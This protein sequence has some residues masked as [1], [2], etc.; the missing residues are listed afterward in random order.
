MAR[1]LRRERP[2][3]VGGNGRRGGKLLRALCPTRG[4]PVRVRP[5]DAVSG[6]LSLP[7]AERRSAHR[8]EIQLPVIVRWTSGSA[9][10]EAV[11][12]SKDISSRGIYYFLL[13]PK[14]IKRGSSIEIV[15]TL[16]HEL[17]LAGPVRVP[18]RAESSV[19]SCNPH[20][21]WLWRQRSNSS[22]SYEATKPSPRG[23]L[24]H[25]SPRSGRR[26]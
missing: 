4:V 10:G 2:P 22:S 23:A 1:N 5:P 9:V 14:D 25:G 16:P 17:I 8:F 11:T 26:E 3:G 18:A 21:K 6:G 20:T 7:G 24:A 12:E 15:M 19:P 13:P